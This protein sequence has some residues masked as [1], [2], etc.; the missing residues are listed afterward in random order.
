MHYKVCPP[1]VCQLTV[2]QILLAAPEMGCE[3]FFVKIELF[4]KLIALPL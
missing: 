1:D 2:I 3:T 4:H